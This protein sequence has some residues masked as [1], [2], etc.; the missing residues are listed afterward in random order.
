MNGESAGCRS[1]LEMM[2]RAGMNT[3]AA[4]DGYNLSRMA[5]IGLYS[6][7]W[8]QQIAYVEALQQGGKPFLAA[9]CLWAE[10]LC[11]V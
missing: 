3:D 11:G 1:R 4:R 7:P 9:S 2:T 5:E 10:N 8:K 6:Q